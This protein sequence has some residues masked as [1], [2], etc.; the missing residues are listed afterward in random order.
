M[1][2]AYLPVMSSPLVIS[3]GPFFAK[4]TADQFFDFCQRNPDLHIERT[5]EGNLVIMSPTG[6]DSGRRE[7]EV[8]GQLYVWS[9]R[10]G[11]GIAFGPSAGFALPKGSTRAPDCSWVRRERWEALTVDQRKKIA[12]LVPDFVVEVRS[13]TDRLSEL[14]DKMEE[15][16]DEGVRL[17]WLIDPIERRVEI[18]RPG[19]VP[20]TL[21]NP[22]HVSA[23]PELRGFT[24]DLTPVW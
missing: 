21:N 7:L 2:I 22:T 15:Y 12:S 4:M 17:G 10:D 11:T 16:A 13:E 3:G 14:R 19:Q 6:I 8:A 1:S 5:R 24:L 20:T 23:D 18:Y 9:K